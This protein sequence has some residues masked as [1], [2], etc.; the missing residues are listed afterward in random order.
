M[1]SESGDTIELRNVQGQTMVLKKDAIQRRGTR[2]FSTMP[3]GLAS[4][5]TPDE[6]ADLLA[7]VE[8]LKG[9]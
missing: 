3:E 4:N 5:L 7:Y 2:D 9:K 8:S 6:L 1:T